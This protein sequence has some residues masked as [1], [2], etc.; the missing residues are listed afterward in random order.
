MS[1]DFTM[2]KTIGYVEWI[3]LKLFVFSIYV[4]MFLLVKLV[5][6]VKFSKMYTTNYENYL[7]NKDITCK[8]SEDRNK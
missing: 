8:I 2:I 4:P 5:L 3:L 1:S 7:R 6:N